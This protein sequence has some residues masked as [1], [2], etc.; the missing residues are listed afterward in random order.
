M[1]NLRKTPLFTP[2][3]RL[4]DVGI[5]VYTLMVPAVIATGGFSFSFFGIAIRASHVYTPIKILLPLVF[6]RLLISME[7]KNFLLLTGSLCL[8][9]IGLEIGIR[10]WDPPISRHFQDRIHRASPTYAWELNPGD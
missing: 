4:L 5:A 1:P 3:K 9:I 2:L 7:F 6:L 8:G 10:A